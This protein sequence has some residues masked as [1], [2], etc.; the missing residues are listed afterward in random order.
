MQIDV[1]IIGGGFSAVATALNLMDCL[2]PSNT[3]AIVA[4][5]KGLGRGVAFSSPEASHRLNVPAGRMSALADRPEHLCD[6]LTREG[7]GFGAEDFIP[8]RLYGLYLQETLAEGMRRVD[9]GACIE[10]IDAEVLDCERLDDEEQVFYL[11]DGRRLRARKSVLCIGGTPAGLPL[12]MDKIAP[13]ARGHLCLNV[14]ADRWI[15]RSDLGDDVMMLGSGLTMIDQVLSLRARGHR[16]RIHILSRHG[17]IPLPHLVP[18]TNPVGPVLEP[19]AK[20]LSAMMRTLRDAA[21]RADD[22]RSVVDGVR[23][24]TQ[25]LW[26]A[27]SKTEKSRFLRHANAWW[28]IHRHRVAPDMWDNFEEMRASGQVTV[29]AGWLRDVYEAGGKIRA[30]YLDRHNRTLRQMSADWLVNCTGMERC[31]ISKTPLLKKMSARGMIDGD[32][33]GL[34]VAVDQDSRLLASDGS[35]N[36]SA[37]ALGPMTI[38]RFFEIF[39]VPD[40]RVQAANVARL[41]ARALM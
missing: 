41:V 20:P 13:E 14:W 30:A 40:I 22:W 2:S 38:G 3:V 27:L 36:A 28:N 32:G 6:W 17:L 29:T 19:G 18:R 39:A 33:L 10:L 34:G 21:A 11:S 7:T 12:P 26:Q 25:A 16:G 31:S 24:I 1:A 37:F 8:R 4:P 23:P 15:E 5:K 35:P 9:N